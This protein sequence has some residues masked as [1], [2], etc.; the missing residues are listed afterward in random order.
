MKK[1]KNVFA[2]MDESLGILAVV[3]A[4]NEKD[5]EDVVWPKRHHET[6]GIWFQKVPLLTKDKS[7]R[8]LKEVV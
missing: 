2:V 1:R 3:D 6:P 7:K 5:A 4:K 8:K